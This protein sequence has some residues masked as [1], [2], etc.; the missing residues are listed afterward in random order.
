ML[1]IGNLIRVVIYHKE[2]PPVYS[3]DPIMRWLCEVIS[4]IKYIITPPAENP[5]IPN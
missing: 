2:L 4:Q 1:M 3:H 5:R